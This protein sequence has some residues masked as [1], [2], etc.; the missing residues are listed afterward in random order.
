MIG[1]HDEKFLELRMMGPYKRQS[2]QLNLDL[3]LAYHQHLPNVVS[4]KVWKY[5]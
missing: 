4:D 1:F 3:F 5:I 2:T